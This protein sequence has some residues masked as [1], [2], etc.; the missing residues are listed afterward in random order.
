M[1][2]FAFNHDYLTDFKTKTEQISFMGKILLGVP[3]TNARIFSSAGIALLHREDL[4]LRKWRLSPTF[5]FGGNFQFDEH[6]MGE[7]AGNFTA[8]FGESRLEPSDSFFPFLYS[9][10]FRFIYFF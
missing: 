10:S 1:S 4:I 5:G 8:G 7:I 3:Y 6:V 9:V 2:L